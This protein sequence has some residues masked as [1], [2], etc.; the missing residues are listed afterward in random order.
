[1][2]QERVRA[3]T[4]KWRDSSLRRRTDAQEQQE[5]EPD[6][7]ESALLAAPERPRQFRSGCETPPM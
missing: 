3:A 4:P 5:A 7:R 2:N 1:V 6:W